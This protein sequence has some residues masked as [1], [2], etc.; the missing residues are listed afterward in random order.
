VSAFTVVNG[1]DWTGLYVDGKLVE[2]GHSISASD[3]LR[4]ARD[5]KKIESVET[6]Y[7]DIDWL[8]DLGWLPD[9]LSD[10]KFIKP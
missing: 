2:Q 9:K 3:A 4:I 8:H 7:A 1:D 5:Y 6:L 10:V